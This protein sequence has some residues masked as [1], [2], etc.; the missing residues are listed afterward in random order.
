MSIELALVLGLLLCAVV[1]F[2]INR[3]RMDFVALL[4]IVA[5]PFTGVISAG[6][7]LAG[8]SDS[9]IVLIA[10]LF[11]LGSG[12]VRTGVA[13]GLGDLLIRRV[14]R[15]ETKLT[16]LLMACVAGLGS[17]MSSTAVTAIFIPVALRVARTTGSTPGRLMMPLSFAAL[18]SGML[19]LVATAPNLVVSAELGRQGYAEFGFFAITP[20]G[21]PILILGIAYMLIVRRFLPGR[22]LG[23]TRDGETP[24]TLAG[25]VDKYA[26]AGREHWLRVLPNSPLVGQTLDSLELSAGSGVKIIALERPGLFARRLLQPT[27][28]TEVQADD[29]LLADVTDGS[30]VSGLCESYGLER[31]DL[32]G[33]YFNDRSQ[34]IGMAEVIVPA[35]SVLLGRSVRE[36]AFRSRTGLT[37]IGL[38]RGSEAVEADVSARELKV[39]DTLLVVGSWKD[40][41]RLRPEDAGVLVLS[42]P[43]E[44]QEVLPASGKAP[45]AVFC[46]LLVMVLM[47]SGV[48]ANVHAALIGC[49]LMGAMGCLTMSSSYRAIDWKT[50]VLIVGMMPFSIAL[51]R[52]GGVNLA[53]DGVVASASGAGPHVLLGAV[54]CMT[55]VTGMFMSNTATAILYAPV[56]IAIAEELGYSP[57]P[58]AMIVALAASTAFVTPVASPVNTLVVTPGNYKFGDFVK[59]GGPFALVVLVTSVILVPLLLPLQPEGPEGERGAEPL[60]LAPERPLVSPGYL[61][62]LEPDGMD[63]AQ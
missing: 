36:S 23:A 32:A 30:L 58:F 6:E 42:V 53:V 55:M 27:A 37:V 18:M 40:I 15:S 59:F 10:A 16:A 61:D 46:L 50:I 9:N 56:S 52:T 21:V 28:K 22:G 7:A 39:G 14:G 38:R 3:P 2:A 17:M 57:Y 63:A 62:G 45:Q 43:I 41:E 12:L 47:V 51:E 11:V 60:L 44:M 49:V 33:T 13:R 31:L 20:V 35:E 48:V 25:F 5:L 54:F 29:I 34:E 26:L 1:M 8:F 19:T 24:A 4:M